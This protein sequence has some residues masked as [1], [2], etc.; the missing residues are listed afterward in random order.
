MG[1]ESFLVAS[2]ITAVISQ[3]LLRRVCGNCSENY[4]PPPQEMA[5]LHAM[6]GHVPDGGFVRGAGCNFCTHTGY[7]ERIGVYEMMAVTDPIRELILNR[8][9]HDDVRKLARAEGMQTL[10]EESVRLVETGVTNLAEVLR[11]IYVVGA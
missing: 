2:S 9:S 4:D 7:L 5:F 11:S 10:Q 6:G 1:I 8:A 3:R